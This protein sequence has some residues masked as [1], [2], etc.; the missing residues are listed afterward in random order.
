MP[1]VQSKK[2]I[3][4]PEVW[5][6]LDHRIETDAMGKIKKAINID[7]IYSSIDNIL[8][9][10]MGE[11][12]FVG[13]TKIKLLN[14]YDVSIKDLV[15]K[16]SWVY[17]FNHKTQ[18][19]EP[20]LAKAFYTGKRTIV[21]VI[22]DN[23][24]TI[25]C[26]SDH[27]F[28][29]RDGEYK[30][31][32]DLQVGES[33]MPLYL[34]TRKKYEDIYQPIS[35]IWE[36]VH[37]RVVLWKMGYLEKDNCVHHK[38]FRR[39]DN[40]PKNLLQVKKSI[41]W[42]FHSGKVQNLNQKLWYSEEYAWFREKVKKGYLKPK[43][44]DKFRKKLSEGQKKRL[45]DPDIRKKNSELHSKLMSEVNSR[46]KMKAKLKEIGKRNGLKFWHSS[47]MKDARE[48]NLKIR[49]FK[50]KEWRES[51]EGQTIMSRN[52]KSVG[53][54][55]IYA[56]F[57]KHSKEVLNNYGELSETAW[58]EYRKTLN[59]HSGVPTWETIS[60]RGYLA[61]L[62]H[63]VK[64]IKFTNE[65][66]DV[67]DL[68]VEDNH[69]FALSAGVF[70]HNCMLPTFAS[71]LHG[72]LFDPITPALQR[73]TANEIKRVIERWDDRVQVLGVDYFADADRNTVEIALTVKV[74]KYSET[75]QY[76]RQVTM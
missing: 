74:R 33:L 32:K 41:H 55:N 22:L 20:A 9:T 10:K 30:E 23:D 54:N 16:Q 28:M 53:E 67:Y 71:P 18:L 12:C 13:E 62:N 15:G 60:S 26:T 3:S 56:K 66:E 42:K 21:E 31:C 24:Q 69:N 43:D 27:K 75:F 7:A 29:L 45:S 37:R 70:V 59:R 11:R 58:E 65:K 35:N 36:R 72:L 34:R 8:G 49:Q 76:R 14:G 68:I 52:G 39:N 1:I 48:K 73:R 47:E 50:A 5:S 44:M 57:L 6:E 61:T 51:E 17:S 63:K 19:I 40:T 25:K 64:S 2:R 4:A 46:P 38:N